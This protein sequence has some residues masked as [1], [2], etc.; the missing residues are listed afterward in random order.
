MAGTKKKET[1]TKKC[2]VFSLSLFEEKTYLLIRKQQS[3]LHC[4]EIL[5]CCLKTEANLGKWIL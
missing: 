5:H 4:L 2:W 1:I 3:I